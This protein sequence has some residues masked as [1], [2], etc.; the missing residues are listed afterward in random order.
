MRNYT[1]AGKAL[2]ELILE[3]FQLN[4]RLLLTGDRLTRPV[5]QTSAR[6]QVMSAVEEQ[7]RSVAQIA[8]DVGLT[9]QSVQRTADR[10]ERD[11]LVSYEDNPAHR[12]AKLV[13]LTSRGRSALAWITRRQI[14][15]ANY[16]GARFGEASVQRALR[17]IRD[18]R[19]TLGSSNWS[20]LKGM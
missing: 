7:P 17:V 11:G 3:V 19:Q 13:T 16:V 12:R 5:G 15:W 10:L 20:G 1:P 4:G 18:F 2:T 14:A 9:R 8:R 6:W